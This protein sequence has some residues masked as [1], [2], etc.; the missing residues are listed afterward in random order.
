[1]PDNDE[2]D[3]DIC[4]NSGLPQNKCECLRCFPMIYRFKWLCADCET[5]DQVISRLEDTLGYFRQLKADGY[6]IGGGIEDDYMEIR[7]QR[8][9]GHYWAKC[10]GCGNIYCTPMGDQRRLC[11]ECRKKEGQ[12][13]GSH[14][15]K[16]AP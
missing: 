6:E 10:K 12:A 5:I 13:G 4:E 8:K 14:K 15:T 11:E 2:E 1:M 7:P 9:E 3:C 16:A